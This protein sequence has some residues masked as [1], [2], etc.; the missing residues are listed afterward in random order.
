MQLNFIAIEYIDITLNCM[1]D[2]KTI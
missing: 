2:S 1:N